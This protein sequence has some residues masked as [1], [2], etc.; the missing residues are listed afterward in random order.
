MGKVVGQEHCEIFRKLSFLLWNWYPSAGWNI[1]MMTLCRH[2][3][4]RTSC[5][6]WC[7][8]RSCRLRASPFDCME[9][10]CSVSPAFLPQHSHT[11][12]LLIPTRTF[13]I[14]TWNYSSFPHGITPH[15]HMELLLIPTWNYSSFPHG[16]TP[17]SHTDLLLI[18]TRNYS[19]FPHGITPHSHTELLLIPTWN[20]SSF[21]H[22][23]TPHSHME[24][25][26]IPTW[27]YSSFPHGITPHSHMEL[28]LIPTWNYSSFPH[29]LTPH[30]HME[31]LLI[32]TRNYSSFPHGITPHWNYSSFPHGITPHSHME[33]LLIPT[34]NY[35]SFPHLGLILMSSYPFTFPQQKMYERMIRLWIF[36]LSVIC[37]LCL[38]SRIM[39]SQSR[40]EL[41][42]FSQEHE[43]LNVLL[44]RKQG[45]ILI[46]FGLDLMIRGAKG[47]IWIPYLGQ[48]WFCSS[49]QPNAG[50]AL[51]SSTSKE[52][53]ARPLPL[54]HKTLINHDFP[55]YFGKAIFTRSSLP[56]NWTVCLNLF[57]SVCSCCPV[58][59]QRLWTADAD[60]ILESQN[61]VVSWWNMYTV[62]LCRYGD[63]RVRAGWGCG[64]WGIVGRRVCG[65][66][67][68]RGNP[69]PWWSMYLATLQ[70]RTLKTPAALTELRGS[71]K[72]LNL[73]ALSTLAL[74]H[75]SVNHEAGELEEMPGDWWMIIMASINEAHTLSLC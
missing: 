51:C 57:S 18:P 63:S 45:W 46:G 17:H 32:P 7:L 4:F 67:V 24:L 41:D 64:T 73:W 49:Q 52:V 39:N 74:W 62:T 59:S 66:G 16:I 50:G 48:V 69:Y 9:E 13:L 40:S 10:P 29:G 28:L 3:C 25:L 8:T 61:R 65:R 21:P 23:I 34:Q 70:K 33:L 5:T 44:G 6:R 19:S 60:L 38:W 20:Y 53:L 35:S 11:E 55:Q 2:W 71:E 31:L 68:L 12:L 36:N 27:N 47:C 26:L 58:S 42:L 1:V 30:S 54:R 22:G 43:L 56:S 75:S 14:P 15:S 72:G 37:Y